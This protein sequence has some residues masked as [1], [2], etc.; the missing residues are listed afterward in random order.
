[1]LSLAHRG[2]AQH[3]LG[4]GSSGTET[5]GRAHHVPTGMDKGGLRAVVTD[6]ESAF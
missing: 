1:M 3:V 6:S 5:F 4:T 2:Q